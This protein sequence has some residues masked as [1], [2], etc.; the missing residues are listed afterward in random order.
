MQHPIRH[1]RARVE[2]LL[3]LVP[4]TKAGASAYAEQQIAAHHVR[5]TLD[6]LTRHRHQRRTMRALV[7]APIR[8]QYPHPALGVDL[9]PA[10]AP[11][12][13]TPASDPNHHPTNPAVIVT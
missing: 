4:R 2:R 10:H 13:L 5:H 6:D 8:W 9:G 3:A 11:D 12:L 1:A 7:L